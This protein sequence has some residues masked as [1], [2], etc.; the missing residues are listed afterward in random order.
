MKKSLFWSFMEQGG[1]KA[2]AMIVQIVLARMLE[3]EDFGVLA[4][5]LVITS[6]A[7]SISQSGLGMA[8]IQKDD[9]DNNSY[10]TGLWL[11]LAISV[12]LYGTVFIGAPLIGNFYN[13]AGMTEYLRVLGVIVLFNAA[14]SIQRSFLQKKMDFRGIC[15]AS[16]TAVVLSGIIGVLAA[17]GGIGVWALVLQSL[18]QSAIMCISMAIIIPWRPSL[19]FSKSEAAGLFSYGWK[20]CITGILNVLYTGVSEL[21]IGKTCNPG[22]LGYYSQGRKYPLAA[23][24][25]ISNAISNVLFPAL[26]AVKNNMDIFRND[27]KKALSVGT[28]VVAPASLLF[29]LTAEPLVAVLLTEKWLPCVLIFQL[30]CIPNV[31]L[32][33]QL[34]NLR[35]YMALGNS[36]L[37]LKLQIIKVTLGGALIC[38]VAIATA[39]IYWTAVATCIAGLLSVLVIDIF[40]AKREHGY[41]ALSQIRDQLPVFFVSAASL[42]ATSLLP[43]AGYSYCI[44][45]IVQVIAFAFIYVTLSAVFKISGLQILRTQLFKRRR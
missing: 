13:I 5:L 21:V 11:S 10:S 6:I 38:G 7:D 30:A 31:F 33:F 2:I 43:V 20:I 14:N 3:P 24:G 35:A 1:S 28:F 36:G 44:Q 27:L 37:Y 23:I 4:I 17:Y 18:S 26:S 29:A 19:T 39:D 22:N 45:L 16:V 25:V 8:L 9:A 40:P 41:G 12:V 32:M 42:L 15:I 34:V